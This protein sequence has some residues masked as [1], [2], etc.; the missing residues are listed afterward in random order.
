LGEQNDISSNTIKSKIPRAAMIN[1]LFPG[2]LPAE[3]TGLTLFEISMISI[4][5]AIT[6]VCLVGGGVDFGKHYSADGGVSY[7][8]INE[9]ADVCTNFPIMPTAATYATL[10]HINGANSRDYTYR[11]LI[12]LIALM[13]LYENNHLYDI[14]KYPMKFPVD[15]PTDPKETDVVDAPFMELTN[16]DREDIVSDIELSSTQQP[17]S[18]NTGRH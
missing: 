3:L 8:I 4:Y 12:I 15:W 10:R 17:Q 13:W 9:L 11:P 6:K 2:A 18:T 7:T 16:T 1:G 5:S 14:R